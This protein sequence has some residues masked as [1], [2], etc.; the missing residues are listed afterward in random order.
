M[1][2]DPKITA[3]SGVI[4]N[5]LRLVVE[6]IVPQEAFEGLNN[7][8]SWKFLQEPDPENWSTQMEHLKKHRDE[9]LYEDLIVSEED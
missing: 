7:G 1:P 3:D 5:R 8:D 6:S 4:M 9:V 2:R